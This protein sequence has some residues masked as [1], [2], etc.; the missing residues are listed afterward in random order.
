MFII[1]LGNATGCLLSILYFE[2]WGS[3]G[4]THFIVRTLGIT[5]VYWQYWSVVV[6]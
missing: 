6:V 3:L 1:N 4:L 5:I 2:G